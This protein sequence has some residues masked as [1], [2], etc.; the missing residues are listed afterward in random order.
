MEIGVWILHEVRVRSYIFVHRCLSSAW[1]GLEG[2]CVR[3]A[4]RASACGWPTAAVC[5][6]L[7]AVVSGWPRFPK[8]VVY[9]WLAVVC[10]RMARGRLRPG[11]LMYAVL[12]GRRG[13]LGWT[14]VFARWPG[15]DPLGRPAGC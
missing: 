12:V 4:W 9:G 1:D 6:W 3:M 13:K 10:V 14:R 8:R 2:V 11:G 15:F 7:A 5:G